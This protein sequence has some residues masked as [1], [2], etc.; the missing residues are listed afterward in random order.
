M[1]DLEQ[2][3]K[4]VFS[5]IESSKDAGAAKNAAEILKLVSEI[6]NQRAQTRKLSIEEEKIRFD[7]ETG[8]HGSK[9]ID[10]KEYAKLLTPVI[11]VLALAVTTVFQGYQ[12]HQSTAEHEDAHRTEVIKLLSQAER[13]KACPSTLLLSRLDKADRAKVVAQFLFGCEDPA[14][15]K[16]AFE[17]SFEPVEWTTLPQI[18]QLNRILGPK[19]ESLKDSVYDKA[20]GQTH[21]EKL[22]DAH[23]KEYDNLREEMVYLSDR[24]AAALKGRGQGQA[25][26]LSYTYILDANLSG[27]DLS[28]ANLTAATLENVNLAHAKLKNIAQSKEVRFFNST[29]WWKSDEISQ[30]LLACL[31]A[32]GDTDKTEYTDQDYKENKTRLLQKAP[33]TE[34]PK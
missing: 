14:S 17:T 8:R 4:T 1:D 21:I 24:I 13:D 29:A 27:I 30:P 2:L 28:G 26:D 23:R 18:V 34:C 5:I 33:G 19:L 11:S 10:W 6:E 22:D 16:S 9:F 32:Y 15:F 7:L 20:T 25:P 31:V 12:L 3:R